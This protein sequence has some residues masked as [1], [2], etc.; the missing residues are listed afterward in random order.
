[1]AQGYHRPSA[2]IGLAAYGAKLY[3]PRMVLARSKKL[4]ILISDDERAALQAVADAAGLTASDYLRQH[5]R[6]AFAAL[7]AAP[8]KAKAGARTARV[9]R[10]A[11][12]RRAAPSKG[13]K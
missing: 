12:A 6:Q 10:I 3:A 1:M 8:K 2:A 11:R 7:D 9:E 5:V 4:T 13:A